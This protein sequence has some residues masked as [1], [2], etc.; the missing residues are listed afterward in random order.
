[1]RIVLRAIAHVRHAHRAVL[2]NPKRVVLLKQRQANK[3]LNEEWDEFH[4]SLERKTFRIIG[5]F[6]QFY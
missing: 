4:L 5:F 3:G 6:L 2:P 1:M